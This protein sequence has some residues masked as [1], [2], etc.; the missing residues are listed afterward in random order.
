[1]FGTGGMFASGIF[2]AENRQNPEKGLTKYIKYVKIGIEKGTESPASI[3]S[4]RPHRTAR[5]T[6]TITIMT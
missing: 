6:P 5:G 2:F 4:V 3:L 1:M